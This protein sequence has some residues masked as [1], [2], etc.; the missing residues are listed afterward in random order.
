MKVLLSALWRSDMIAQ[1]LHSTGHQCVTVEVGDPTYQ[2][3]K[4]RREEGVI[5]HFRQPVPE[6]RSEKCVVRPGHEV[7]DMIEACR[8][9]AVDGVVSIV[10]P[11]Y[12]GGGSM[13]AY[14]RDAMLRQQ[15]VGLGI[16]VVAHSAE[17]ID[18]A[19]DKGA[20]KAFCLNRGFP[21]PRGDLAHSSETARE[22]AGRIGLPVIMKPVQAAGGDGLCAADSLDA[23]AAYFGGRGPFPPT[24]VEEYV[25][26]VEVSVEVL[27]HRGR[28]MAL[29]PIFKGWTSGDHPSHRT[30]LAPAPLPAETSHRLMRMCEDLCVAL[31]ADGVCD[32]DLIVTPENS[33]ILE[34]NPRP[35][36]STRIG[37]WATGVN[38]YAAF[39]AMLVDQWDPDGVTRQDQHV[40]LLPVS[41]PLEP[42]EPRLLLELPGVMQ[43]VEHT[44][45]LEYPDPLP[46][47]FLTAGDQGTL[48]DRLERV[49]AMVPLRDNPST[50]AEVCRDAERLA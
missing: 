48:L 23:I 17:T 20:M 13:W 24:V 22:I 16:P 8:T 6:L 36:G 11:F 28:A 1:A 42:G 10:S 37:Y 39:L 25:S 3:N 27:V 33:Y 30:R 41:R 19:A 46:R 34:V 18:I 49:A 40:M 47:I 15:L 26:G 38:I 50:L 35:S 9:R 7:E 29:T 32:L 5:H 43:V 44:P 45:G 4:R 2:R 14:R 21:T 12:A 31:A